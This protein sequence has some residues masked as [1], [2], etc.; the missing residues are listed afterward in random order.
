MDERPD[1][2]LVALARAGDKDAFGQLA[3]RH[4]RSARAV[5][6]RTVA[7]PDVANDLVQEALVQAYLSLG[8]LRDGSRFGSWLYGIVLNVCR[9]Y[10]RARQALSS[11]EAQ[12]GGIQLDE[13]SLPSLDPGPHEVAEEQEFHRAVLAAVG[14][15]PVS[16]RTVTLLYY[17]EQLSL[18]EIAAILGVSVVGVK[19]RLHRARKRLEQRLRPLQ[20]ERGPA[21]AP[22]LRRATMVRV[23]LADVVQR[24]DGKQHVVVLLDEAGRRILPIWV[25]PS[26]GQAIA[27][28]LLEWQPPRPLTYE[29]MASMLDAAGAQVDEVRIEALK[30]GVFYAVAKLRGGDRVREV[31]AR[32]SDAIALALRTRSPIYA[33]DEVL[34]EAGVPIPEE[35]GQTLRPGRGLAAIAQELEEKHKAASQPTCAISAEELEKGRAELIAFVFGNKE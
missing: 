31:D 14:A 13:I 7:D 3:E 25:G 9:S 15:L 26:E 4:Q 6:L 27:A 17:Y 8:H 18:R 22:Q 30:Q 24:N 1:A 20:A 16:D 12:A 34:A 21:T 19:V 2:E 29:L 23:T 32:P 5:A 11:R 10:V 35:L 28:R 33:S